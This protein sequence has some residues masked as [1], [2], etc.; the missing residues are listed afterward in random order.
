MGKGDVIAY[1][2]CVFVSALFLLE[3]G[4]DKFVDHTAAVARRTGIPQTIIAL[5]SA[6]ADWEEVCC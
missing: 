4:A 5:L 2:A 1:D 3:Q 6:G